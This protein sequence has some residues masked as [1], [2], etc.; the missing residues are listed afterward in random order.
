MQDNQS[1]LKKLRLSTWLVS[2]LF[3]RYGRVIGA[4]FISGI[5]VVVFLLR[6]GP[7]L[8]QLAGRGLVTGLVGS[9]S[10]SNLP[11]QIEKLISFGLTSISA[12]GEAQPE[13]ATSW[14]VDT[15]GTEYTFHLR[16]DVYW[17]DKKKFTA[18]DVNYN[19]KD[20]TFT[21]VSDEVLK[22]K[23]KDSFSPL[24]T[25]L[26]KPL[27]RK[28]LVG[29]GPYKIESLRLRGDRVSYLKLIPV[30]SDLPPIEVKFYPSE[31]ALTTAFK[32]GEVTSI[33]DITDPTPFNGWKNTATE[34]VEKNNQ[35]VTI[36]FNL[37]HQL[38]KTKD[39][40]QALAYAF[41]KPEKN[42]VSTSFSNKSWAYTSRV[43]Q[44]EK[45][46]VTA[47]KLLA[48]IKKSSDAASLTLSTFTSHLAL[49]QDIASAW[50]GV[51]I[52]TKV[53]VETGMP[54][55]FDVLL[56]IQEIPA[57][58]DQY[59]M[60]HSTQTAN[61]I[62]HYG[63]PK[64]DKLLEDGRKEIDREKRKKLY[65]DFQRYIIEDVP[66]IFLYHPTTYTIT[67]K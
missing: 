22:V 8:R 4:S 52:V 54:Q 21:P 67:R 31:A 14:E 27:F 45:D 56:A 47:N 11:E 34:T 64:I 57:D 3:K 48:D 59:T 2:G 51:G 1:L 20:V 24:P 18:Y 42:R 53:K 30:H 33:Y 39:V 25:F 15:S 61:N 60:W 55:I 66:A 10:P 9:Y 62:T 46:L 19:L 50:A 13:L 37:N 26:A 35:I 36:F 40:R 5:L 7:Y 23:L 63:S 32:L 65:F 29:V 38:L 12:S 28:G 58:P 16:N 17:H 49:A 44:Y 6:F 43:K 41:D